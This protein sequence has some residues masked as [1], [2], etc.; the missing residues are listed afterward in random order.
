[1]KLSCRLEVLPGQ[2]VREQVL[3]AQRYG[4]D[5]I[6]LPGRFL[7]RFLP[8]LESIIDEVPIPMMSLSL[9][10]QSSLLHPLASERQRCRESLRSLMDL[11]Q[12]L[13]VE[14]LNVAPVLLQ[15]NPDRI[16][17][18]GEFDSLDSR[19]DALLLEQLGE[20]GD[21]AREREVVLL[22]EPVNRF[23]SEY[24]HSIEH[25]A[26]LCETAA[27]SAVGMTI[28]AFHMQLEELNLE[29][30]VVR[31]GTQIRHVHVAENTRVE[32]GVG[33]LDLASVF[34]GLQQVDYDDWIEVE[35]RK[36]SG[37]ADTV[38]PRSVDYLRSLWNEPGQATAR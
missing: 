3:N 29:Q 4:F 14:R 19:L 16:C 21:A 34:R 6:G 27:H 5:G 11:C 7:D 25:G 22:V 8:E 20:L 33:S 35:C 31:A 18:A 37:P 10:F 17:E 2:S 15:D 12:R 36:L 9:G 24:L 32:P 1:M 38:L 26:R 30:A 23:E 28:D 13:G